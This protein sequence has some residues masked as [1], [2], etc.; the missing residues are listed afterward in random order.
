MAKQTG[1]PIKD[2]SV[3]ATILWRRTNSEGRVSHHAQPLRNLRVF[4]NK[5]ERKVPHE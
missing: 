3:T 2:Q 1:I 4:Q 5:T